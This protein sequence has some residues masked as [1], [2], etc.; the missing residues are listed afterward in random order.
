MP[1]NITRTTRGWAATVTF[2]CG[3]PYMGTSSARRN[4]YRTRAE[5]RA[6]DI[7]DTH[8]VASEWV[9]V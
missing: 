8:F 9:A 4:T 6:A 2:G 1:K 5:A 7:S 3:R